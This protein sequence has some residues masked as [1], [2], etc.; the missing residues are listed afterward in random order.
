MLYEYVTNHGQQNI[1]L[2]SSLK[3]KKKDC[4]GPAVGLNVLG[5]RKLLPLPGFE[6]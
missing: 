4:V 6:T 5:E 3:K 1:K 2:L